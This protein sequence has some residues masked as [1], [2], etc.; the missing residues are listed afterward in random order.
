VVWNEALR[1]ILALKRWNKE[2]YKVRNFTILTL[3][4]KPTFVSCT[5]PCSY[6]KKH[7]YF[8]DANLGVHC[9]KM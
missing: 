6:S 1:R 8:E 5:K 7:E 9:R 4:V 2:N 3:L